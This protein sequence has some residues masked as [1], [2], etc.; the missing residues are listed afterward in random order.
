MFVQFQKVME[1]QMERT[2]AAFATQFME[3]EEK[4]TYLSDLLSTTS[5]AQVSVEEGSTESTHYISSSLDSPYT[6]SPNSHYTLSSNPTSKFNPNVIL[7]DSDE[8]V[9][10][11]KVKDLKTFSKPSS[12]SSPLSFA[13]WYEP[14]NGWMNATNQPLRVRRASL[15][16]YLSLEIRSELSQLDQNTISTFDGLFQTLCSKYTFTYDTETFLLSQLS[17][18]KQGKDESVGTYASRLIALS[19]KATTNIVDE[20][21]KNFFIAGLISSLQTKILDSDPSSFEVAQMEAQRFEKNAIIINSHYS[22]SSSNSHNP[23]NNT[24]N[25][26]SG[27]CTK[28]TC[29][30][31]T[32][33]NNPLCISCHK[34]NNN[35]SS[36]STPTQ[37]TSHTPTPPSYTPTFS[38]PTPNPKPLGKGTNAP[39]GK[40]TPIPY[41][42]N[43]PP[44]FS[45]VPVSYIKVNNSS[46]DPL[47]WDYTKLTS[48]KRC[49]F[50]AQVMQPNHP[51]ASK[52]THYFGPEVRTL[53]FKK[54][55]IPSRTSKPLGTPH[56]T[57]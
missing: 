14:F 45:L 37:K 42:A 10:P 31:P 54:Y 51:C 21:M 29:K 20:T 55:S 4:I 30:N 7:G 12:S 2:R 33:N 38:S 39:K 13:Q 28:G 16:S 3:Q 35:S 57:P 6:I 56:Q 19:K 52:Y 50:C 23:S 8:T 27:V 9:K 26:S 41:D 49:H 17:N 43:N 53:L 36:T 1:D 46:S 5:M 15:Y 40:V 24:N 34:S 11:V 32:R 48:E 18:I 47:E 44:D 25:S 22:S